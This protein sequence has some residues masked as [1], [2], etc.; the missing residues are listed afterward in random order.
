MGLLIN[1]GTA[2]QFPLATTQIFNFSSLYV[3]IENS[4][5]RPN[6]HLLL[7]TFDNGSLF[8]LD[9]SSANPQ[10]ELIAELPGATALCGIATIGSDKFAVVGGVRG[11]YHYDNETIYTV[12]FSNNAT[13]ATIEVAATIPNA[14][15]LNGSKNTHPE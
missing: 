6:G 1:I 8:T 7:S 2:S 12:D 14:S 9:P 13:N 10:A 11:S 3:D 4:H 5:L 15:M